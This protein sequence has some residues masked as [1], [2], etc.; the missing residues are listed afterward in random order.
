MAKE[1]RYDIKLNVDGKNVVASAV[2]DVKDLDKS[3]KQMSHYK[4]AFNDI[5]ESSKPM[6][7]QLAELKKL[8]AEMEFKGLAGTDEF[9]AIAQQAGAMADAIGDANAQVKYFA[10]D[11]KV[12]SSV[13]GGFQAVASSIQLAQGAMA[14]FGSENKEAAEMIKKVQGAMALANGVQQVANL[15]NKDSALIQGVANMQRKLSA[16]LARKN[17]A[18]VAAETAAT[19]GATIAT[20]ALNAVMKANPIGLVITAITTLVGLLAVFS[21]STDES[22]EKLKKQEEEVD[23][24]TGSWKNLQE[25]I[26]NA[27]GELVSKF[28]TLALQ[29]SLLRTEGERQQWISKNANNFEQLGLKIMDVTTA[30]KVFIAQL[31]RMITLMQKMGELKGLESAY[32]QVQSDYFSWLLKR[33]KSRA[34]GDYYTKATEQNVTKAEREELGI[35]RQ[36]WVNTP[37]SSSAGGAGGYYSYEYSADELRRVNEY[38]EKQAKETRDAILKHAEEEYGIASD[39]YR[40]LYEKLYAEVSDAGAELN[41]IFGDAVIYNPETT[42]SPYSKNKSG[43]MKSATA[44]SAPA[45]KTKAFKAKAVK[46]TVKKELT[47]LQKLE[48]EREELTKR[49][50]D[51]NLVEFE[52][53]SIKQKIEELTKEIDFRKSWTADRRYVLDLPDNKIVVDWENAFDMNKAGMQKEWEDNFNKID[54]ALP[55]LITP[56][57]MMTDSQGKDFD[58]KKAVYDNASSGIDEVKGWVDAGLIGRD[59]AQQFIDAFNA[60]MQV[61]GLEPIKVEFDDKPAKE[62]FKTLREG[63]GGAQGIVGGV[64]NLNNALNGNKSVWEQVSGVINATLQIIDGFKQAAQVVDLFTVSTQAATTATVAKTAAT[65]ADTTASTVNSVANAT[66]AVTK[67]TAAGASAGWPALLWAIPAALAAVMAGLALAGAFA[68]GGIV[69]GSSRSGDHVIARVNSGEMILNSVQQKRLFGMLNGTIPTPGA[70]PTASLA[71]LRNNLSSGGN[72]TMTV[73]GRNLVGVLSNETR[74]SS[75]SGRRTNIKI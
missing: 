67:G 10:N 20:K 22:T 39:E 58:R 57:E 71:M 68:E 18:A 53:E 14:L 5:V 40:K 35:G 69:G 62:W 56:R 19:K 63:W 72:M 48:A 64:E 24:L 66:E 73:S 45:P 7:R 12:L 32:A 42:V 2:N 65:Q 15:L 34:T 51:K 28:Q 4:G 30:N 27:A 55:K 74:I 43:G 36:I 6:K 29:W 9:K 61:V 1:I 41:R 13:V 46:E 38:R 52:R 21:S 33:E 49:L 70:V 23:K 60:Q 17:A 54:F 75:R 44:K 47:E 8:M 16:M 26:G 59:T 25:G 3:V 50:S 37:Y 11:T 31:P